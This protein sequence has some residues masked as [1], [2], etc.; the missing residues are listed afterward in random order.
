MFD[1]TTAICQTNPTSVRRLHFH[2]ALWPLH[3]GCSPW[4]LLF[5][6]L[7]KSIVHLPATSIIPSTPFIF[8]CQVSLV[9]CNIKSVSDFVIWYLLFVIKFHSGTSNSNSGPQSS[10]LQNLFLACVFLCKENHDSQHNQR[11]YSQ[12]PGN[13]I[14]SDFLHSYN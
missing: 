4:A 1:V 13:K 2:I 12:K 3:S 9:S 10:S 6:V 14:I 8:A 5:P 7:F 11:I